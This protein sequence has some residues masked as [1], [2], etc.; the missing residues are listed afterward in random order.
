M[1]K[2]DILDEITDNVQGIAVA[3]G[4]GDAFLL[5]NTKSSHFPILKIVFE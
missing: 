2:N 4:F 3:M 5:L 1:F